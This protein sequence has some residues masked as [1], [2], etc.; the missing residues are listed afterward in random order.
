M[1]VTWPG[2]FPAIA[3]QLHADHSWNFD[4]T[5]RRRE[6][7]IAA[8]IDSVVFLGTAGGK[9]AHEDHEKLSALREVKG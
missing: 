1:K 9:T 5:A 6:A 8:G 7:T 3:T 4:G 2:V